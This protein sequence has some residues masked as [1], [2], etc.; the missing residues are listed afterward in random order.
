MNQLNILCYKL[1]KINN[2]N[3]VERK[4]NAKMSLT[5]V[6]TTPSQKFDFIRINEK[7]AN[8]RIFKFD[9]INSDFVT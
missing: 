9:V 1:L 2:R 8:H 6:N 3:A 4:Q 5:N 7:W